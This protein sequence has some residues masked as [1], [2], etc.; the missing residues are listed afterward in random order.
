MV[1]HVPGIGASASGAI[2]IRRAPG[3]AP[4]RRFSKEG[5]HRT[6]YIYIYKTVVFV[7][8][9]QLIGRTRFP[10]LHSEID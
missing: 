7:V 2:F 10:V 3:L 6:L 1:V 4:E 9:S 8:C 5:D